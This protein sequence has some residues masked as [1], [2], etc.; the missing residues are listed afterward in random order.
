MTTHYYISFATDDAFLGAII[1]KA[2]NE[3][4]AYTNSRKL[5]P[6][7]QMVAIPIPPEHLHQFPMSLR[8]RLLDEKT[9]REELSGLSM[10]EAEEQGLGL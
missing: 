10:K 3:K 5:S 6:G 1:I 8:D 9:I 4:E 7:G 2:A